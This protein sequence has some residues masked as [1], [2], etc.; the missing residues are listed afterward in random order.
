[1]ALYEP[2]HDRLLRFCGARLRSREEARDVASETVLRAYERFGELRAT[3]AFL[4]FLFGIA[5]RVIRERER[6]GRWW[7]LFSREAAEARPTPDPGPETSAEVRLLYEALEH[8]PVGQREAVVLFEIA[9]LSLEE[10]RQVQGGSLSGVKSRVVRGRE[11][12][13]RRLGE[14][15]TTRPADA[16]ASTLNMELL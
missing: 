1:M 6:R 11:A 4:G 14:R 12:L 7:G 16:V 5:L 9:G 2:V 3:E 10:V 15:P 8:L 13:A